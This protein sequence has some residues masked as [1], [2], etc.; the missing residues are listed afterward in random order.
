MENFLTI[1]HVSVAVLLVG[2]ILIQKDRGGGLVGALGGGG[3]SPFGIKTAD[4]LIKITS[5]L[6]VLFILSALVLTRMGGPSSS[7]GEPPVEEG[8]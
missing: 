5:V 2:I 1:V 6:F 3:G 8:E 7:S 4:V